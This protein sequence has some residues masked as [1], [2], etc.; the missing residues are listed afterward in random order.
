[1]ELLYIRQDYLD[2]LKNEFKINLELGKYYSNVPFI[3][4]DS[5]NNLLLKSNIFVEDIDLKFYTDGRDNS[6]LDFENSK[7]LYLKFK[8]LTPRQA[9][10]ER[11]WQY[12]LHTKFWNYMRYRWPLEKNNDPDHYFSNDK[13]DR[14]LIRHGIARLWWIA[15][16]TYDSDNPTDPFH[17]TEYVFND[18]DLIRNVIERAF[19]RNK[20]FTKNLLIC[21]KNYFDKNKYPNKRKAIRS[22]M[23]ELNRI[24][25]IR[26]VEGLSIN[27]LNCIVTD[28]FD[29]HYKDFKN[30]QDNEQILLPI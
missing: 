9:A 16:E 21:I 18:K 24:S 8:F 11:L 30:K 13:N 14:A 6:S 28:F 15:H 5:N 27:D 20:Q 1:M 12:L 25:A 3:S 19:F 7:E 10:D 22:L 29:N 4:D 17:L 2:T 23:P 26:I